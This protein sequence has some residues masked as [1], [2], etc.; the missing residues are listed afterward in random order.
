MALLGHRVSFHCRT[1]KGASFPFVRAFECCGCGR[2]DVSFLAASLKL[3]DA[4]HEGKDVPQVGASSPCQG[5]APSQARKGLDPRCLSMVG[6]TVAL[7]KSGSEG[8]N[9]MTFPAIQSSHAKNKTCQRSE[10]VFS[11]RWFVSRANSDNSMLRAC[12][13]GCELTF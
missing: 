10:S 11:K 12:Q 7:P 13:R 8:E 6:F 4:L 2:L 5:P 9:K 3:Y 1:C